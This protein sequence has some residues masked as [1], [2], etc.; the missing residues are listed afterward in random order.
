M[1]EDVLA[2]WTLDG[3]IEITASL[4]GG[5]YMLDELREIADACGVDP[6]AGL[7]VAWPSAGHEDP[8][9]RRLKKVGILEHE[10][11]LRDGI[12]A[13][14]GPKCG[15]FYAEVYDTARWEALRKRVRDELRT[16]ELPESW[17]V[18]ENPGHTL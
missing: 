3:G 1:I 2:T 5:R 18:Q 14:A 9:A 7:D 13:T 16:A 11:R 4:G 10:G 17:T 12:T 6:G 15:D 8:E